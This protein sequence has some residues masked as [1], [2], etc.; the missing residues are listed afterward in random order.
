MSRDGVAWSWH[1]V[2]PELRAMAEAVPAL[3]LTNDTLAAFRAS[4]LLPSDLS[5]AARQVSVIRRVIPRAGGGEVE[6]AVYRPPAAGPLGGVLHLH[7][8]GFVS[9]S[10]SASEPRNRTL[11]ADLGCVV[12]GVGY[13]LAP[14]HRFP[15]AIE[16][17]Y[18]GLDFIFRSAA[19]LGIDP[20]RI[21]LKGESAGGGLAAALAIMAR[22]RGEHRLALQHLTYPML[23][24]RTGSE[25]ARP[26]SAG[27]FV[28]TAQQ[29]AFAWTSLLGKM[30]GTEAV[31]PYAAAARASDLAGLPPTYIMTGALDLFADE[32]IDYARRL[33]EAGVPVELH[34]FPGAFHGFDIV[35]H[36]SV[37]RAAR[38]AGRAALARALAG[39]GPSEGVP[40]GE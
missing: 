37:A 16:D 39:P 18:A 29:N 27:E 8:G 26:S 33:I 12:V 36:A 23:D 22:D 24:D 11:A 1:M 19:E 40:D 15:A 14:E 31:P 3:A 34:V 32:D 5:E 35:E 10:L 17:A 38:A 2:D 20:R 28:W 4:V 25:S 7:G 6:L 30:R 13:R 21:V 9:G